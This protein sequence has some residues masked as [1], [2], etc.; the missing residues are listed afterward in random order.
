VGEEGRQAAEEGGTKVSLYRRG[1]TWWYKFRFAGQVIRESSKSESKTIAKDAERVR[2]RELEES[3]NQIKRRKLPPLFSL[4]AADWI[5][6]RTSIAP[7][8]ERSY[9]LAISQLTNDFGKQLLCD[10]SGEDLAAYQTRRKRDGVS[11]R[12]VNLELGV[13]RS[14][15]RRYRMWEP[16]AADVDF[17]KEN[18]SP[19]RALSVDEEMRLLDAASRSRCRSLY[20]VVM[21]ALN[22][23]MRAGEIRGLTWAQVDFL[24]GALTVGKSKTVAGTGR[25]IPLNPRAVAVLG[26]WRAV[27]TEAQPEHYVFPHEKY[28]LAGNDRKLCAYEIVPTEPMHR[29]KVAW[30]SARRVAKVFCRFHD[31]RHTFISKL[32]ESQA[33]DSTVMALAGHVSRAMMERYSHIRMEAKRRAVDGLSGTDFEPGVAQ[34]WAQYYVSEISEEAKSLKIDGE[35]GR[36]RTYNPLIS[37]AW[38]WC[39][40]V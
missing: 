32:A 39:C 22:T 10:L 40:T 18:A 9:K 19:G 4:A 35:P 17:L 12:T 33:S 30:E 38:L 8:T 27:F 3:W 20:P 5:K 7:S 16:I 37:P 29:W 31:L 15:L 11:N 28:G 36:T 24:A 1:E 13:L 14:I 23:G 6:T 26:H 25:I 34:N 2:R 21:L